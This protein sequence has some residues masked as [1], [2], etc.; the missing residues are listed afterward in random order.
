MTHADRQS[1]FILDII[2]LLKKYQ[3]R[4][5]MYNFL[6][7]STF[8]SICHWKRLIKSKINEN[9]VLAWNSYQTFVD[10]ETWSMVLTGYGTPLKQI[11]NCFLLHI[12]YFQFS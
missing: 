6:V 11:A 3:L 4:H 12:N 9:V 5:I 7:N 8:P 10:L 1:G 2:R